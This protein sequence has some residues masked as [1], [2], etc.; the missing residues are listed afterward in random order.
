M[1][2]ILSKIQ[3]I[4]TMPDEIEIQ[5]LKKNYPDFFEKTSPEIIKF[6]LSEKT[7][8]QIADICE[9]NGVME[10]EKIEGI[11]YR[12]AWVL[13]GKLPKENLA[14]TFERGVG[15]APE[16]AKKIADE[17]NQFISSAS[18]QFKSG[19]IVQPEKELPGE[20]IVEE[21][22]KRPSSK[23]VYRESVE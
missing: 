19:E 21:K 18:A 12:I 9:K 1:E 16:I 5:N 3:F 8:G 23:D 20:T 4:K 17:A 13:L 22:P 15:L 11:A 10:E 6:I 7:A 2:L 14:L